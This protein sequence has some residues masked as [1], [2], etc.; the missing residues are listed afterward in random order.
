MTVSDPEH[1]E[2]LS[3]DFD[4]G[5]GLR[6]AQARFESES[7]FS[8]S[9]FD[10]Y[11]RIRIL[12]Y[13]AGVSAIVRLLDRHG[14][15]DFEC[16]FGCES[17]LRT[18]KDILAFQQVAIGDTRA[19]IKN[20]SDE[21]HAFIL[22]RVREGQARFRVLRKQ[23]AHAKLYLLENTATGTT[24]ALIGS[25]NLSETAFGGRQSETL[26]CFDDDAAAWDYYLGM[27]EAIRDRASDEMP[28]PP[29]W[30]EKTEIALQEVPVLATHDLSTLVIDNEESE[31][32]PGNG[33][34]FNVPAQIERIEKMKAALPPPIASLIPPPRN[35]KQQITPDIR[36][37]IVRE[38]SRIRSV[39]TEEEADH[40]ELSIDRDAKTVTLLGE[41]LALDAD[42]AAAKRDANLLAAFF[43]S[44]EGTFEGGM[45]V[46]RLQ[47]DYF[48]LWSWL[49]FAPFMCD[50]RTLA[51]HQGDIFRFPSFAIVY[52]KP[53]CGKSSLIETLMTSM[54]GKAFTIDKRE[55]TKAQ[56]RDIQHNYKRFPA[57]FD[58]IGRAAIRSHGEDVIKDENPPLVP[59]FPCFVLSMNQELKAFT[60]QIVKRSLMI[61]TTTAL[62]SYKEELRHELHLKI[63]DVRR[64]LSPHFYREYLR[65]AL[66]RFDDDPHPADWLA[67]SSTVLAGLLG[68]LRDASPPK[69][70][71]P[72]TWD[73]YA[74][75]RYEGVKTRIEHLLRPATRMKQEGDQPIGWILEDDKIIVIEQTDTFGRREFD[76][77]NVPSTL[78]DENASVGG[79]TVLNRRELEEFLDAKLSGGRNSLFAKIFGR[80]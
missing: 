42:L 71:T 67:F 5:S 1:G 33:A 27:Y 31:P 11:D 79:R 39:Q 12:T 10:G 28:L 46:E 43:S 29:E 8:W 18:L 16:V 32:E 48:I 23:I 80:R 50:M 17:T 7:K 63:Q 66:D 52:G 25:A 70:C 14:F 72:L 3:L 38:S 24:R 37:S 20:L 73:D 55:F 58:D 76:W 2:T 51:G 78:I 56:L 35:G 41:P 65:R 36:R 30:V 77:E 60:D 57:V 54:F 69:W 26:V 19:A 22:S 53:S 4:D 59:E 61:Y 75:K 34:S 9:L 21:R 45:G 15:S 68:D 64:S 13:S 40:R 74:G 49:Y 6:V 44:Y 47:R 62:P